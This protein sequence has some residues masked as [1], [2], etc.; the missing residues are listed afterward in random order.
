MKTDVRL[1]SLIPL[2]L[3]LGCTSQ[4]Y[5]GDQPQIGPSKPATDVTVEL[6]GDD[7]ICV[8]ENAVRT[9]VPRVGEEEGDAS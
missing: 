6:Q 1:G 4:G 7:M 8:T 2:M 3:M 9:C 5:M